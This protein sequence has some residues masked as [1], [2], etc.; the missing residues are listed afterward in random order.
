MSFTILMIVLLSI[1]IG[2]TVWTVVETIKSFREQQDKLKEL[3]DII[4]VYYERTKKI[5]NN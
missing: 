4:R 2:M 5:T 3:D 1:Q